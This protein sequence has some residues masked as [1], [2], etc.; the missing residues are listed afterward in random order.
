MTAH[1]PV[2]ERPQGLSAAYLL[3]GLVFL[4]IALIVQAPASLLKKALPANLPVQI[5]SFGGTIWNGQADWQQGP[6]EGQLRWHL[7]PLALLTGKL[8]ADIETLGAVQL[9]ARAGVGLGGSWTVENLNGVIPGALVQRFLP[10]GW[11]LPGDYRAQNVS[12]ARAKLNQGAW[13]LAGGSL[14]WAGGS[15]HYS[16]NGQAQ[17]ATLP[18]LVLNLRLDN[19]VLALNLLEETGSL[20]L[21]SLRLSADN[22]LETQLR[23]RLLGYTPNYHGQGAPDQVVVTAKQP[24]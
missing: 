4:I 7:R 3:W 22:M 6:D 14:H 17:G 1:A 20:G 21:G 13:K 24:L 19:D 23:Q 2:A 16:V 8:S 5:E 15:M 10:P 9:H 18:P 12:V 11:E